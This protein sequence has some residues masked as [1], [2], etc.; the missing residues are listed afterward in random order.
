M[1]THTQQD[2]KRDFTQKVKVSKDLLLSITK[3][4]SN[5]FDW[6]SVSAVCSLLPIESCLLL[7][8]LFCV[9]GE[10]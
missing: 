2:I 1:Y 7:S 4:L 5:M 6:N 3:I 9:A 8:L 10:A